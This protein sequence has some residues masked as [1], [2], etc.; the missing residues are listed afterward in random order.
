MS[1]CNR[2]DDAIGIYAKVSPMSP[3]QRLE[4]CTYRSYLPN[5]YWL[6]FSDSPELLLIIQGRWMSMK[7]LRIQRS[8]D[9]ELC[10]LPE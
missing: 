9:D 5:F 4:L 7:G 2:R 8:V 6:F 3:K 1:F 10:L